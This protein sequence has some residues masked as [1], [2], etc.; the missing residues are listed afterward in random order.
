MLQLLNG[1]AGSTSKCDRTDAAGFCAHEESCLH[2]LQAP[3]AQRSQ[4]GRICAAIWRPLER[5]TRSF[6]RSKSPKEIQWEFQ[7]L[8]QYKVSCASVSPGRSWRLG[9]NFPARSPHI[10]VPHP[11]KLPSL[12]MCS[13][14]AV[15]ALSAYLQP[16]CSFNDAN[17]FWYVR[18]HG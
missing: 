15:H 4:A 7:V 1:H 5:A 13:G 3:R 17:M 10:K 6:I 9:R 11:Y 2:L 16:Q 8:E 12:D 14:C 18:C